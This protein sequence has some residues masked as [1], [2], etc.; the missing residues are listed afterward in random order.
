MICSMRDGYAEGQRTAGGWRTL[1]TRP[2]ITI[3]PRLLFQYLCTSSRGLYGCCSTLAI[4]RHDEFSCHLFNTDVRMQRDSVDQPRAILVDL[5]LCDPV[6]NGNDHVLFLQYLSGE[7]GIKLR[8][9]PSP[10]AHEIR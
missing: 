2:I 4:D 5:L 10:I 1:R 9:C 8:F 6:P 3:E 7:N